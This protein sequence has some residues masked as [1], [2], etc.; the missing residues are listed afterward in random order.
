MFDKAWKVEDNI[1]FSWKHQIS[2]HEPL[3]LSNL[4]IFND[5]S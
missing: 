1:E 4:R 2:K 3:K 5:L